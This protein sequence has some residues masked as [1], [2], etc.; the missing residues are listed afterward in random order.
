MG[1]DKGIIQTHKL[2]ARFSEPQS[3]TII[4]NTA[5]TGIDL[6]VSRR[7]SRYR[8]HESYLQQVVIK[9]GVPVGK[10][11]CFYPLA[12]RKD[13]KASRSTFVN[14]V[15][16][17]RFTHISGAC[18]AIDQHP[19]VA[20]IQIIHDASDS[21]ERRRTN[22]GGRCRHRIT[23]SPSYIRPRCNDGRNN[24]KA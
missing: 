19:K 15:V 1:Y 11:S 24:L 5:R 23:K 6:C 3:S 4:E 17:Q 16:K 2:R 10:A 9:H 14:R 13:L 21:L 20:D 22:P 8:Y 18:E 7:Q 12:H